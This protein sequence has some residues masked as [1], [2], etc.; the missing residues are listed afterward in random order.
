MRT[1]NI[2]YDDRNT[3]L[4]YGGFWFHEGTWNA[5]NVDQSGTL[6]SSND[7]NAT[8]TFDFPVPAIAFH[9]FGIGRSRGGLYGICID[10]DAENPRFQNVDG[11]NVSDNGRNPPVAL[12]SKV[13]DTPAKHV[14]VLRN[15]N[16]TRRIPSGNSQM[17]ID[18]F[19]LEVIEDSPPPVTPQPPSPLPTTDSGNAKPPIGAIVGGAIGGLV[20]TVILTAIGFRYR[21]RRRNHLS[22]LVSMHNDNEASPSA[23]VPYPQRHP[24]FSKEKRLKASLSLTSESTD[25]SRSSLST[26][27]DSHSRRDSEI[28]GSTPIEDE[29][30]TLPPLYAEV[31]QAGGVSNRPPSGQ[32]PNDTASVVRNTLKRQA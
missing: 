30:S 13:F 2:T 20:L 10:C 6:S 15:Q 32:A 9:Y 12:F 29:G 5:S 17:T 3:T 25:S 31:F 1:K 8:V 28:T 16:D 19:V 14:M 4:N 23:V 7:P 26:T 22:R 24:S 18:R 21:R 11:L 27:T